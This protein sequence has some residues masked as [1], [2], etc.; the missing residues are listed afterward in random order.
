MDSFINLGVELICAEKFRSEITFY[1][2]LKRI[3]ARMYVTFV[4]SVC[5]MHTNWIAKYI[6]VVACLLW[7]V[8]TFHSTKHV[9]W[10]ESANL[11]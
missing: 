1:R 4:N 2:P 8:E 7:K 11:S 10:L 5:F 9:V 3:H 6:E